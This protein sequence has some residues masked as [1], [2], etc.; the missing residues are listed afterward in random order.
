MTSIRTIVV[1]TD[2]SDVTDHVLGQ[3]I[4]LC[5][6][7]G[8]SI[9]LVHSVRLPALSGVPAAGFPSGVWEAIHSSA[10]FQMEELQKKVEARGVTVSTEVVDAQDPAHAAAR[11]A[12]EHDADWIVMGTHGHT[13]LAHSLLGSVAE[14]TIRAAQVPVLSVKQG[15]RGIEE[16]PER[17]LMATDFSPHSDRAIEVAGDYASRVGAHVHLLHAFE[18]PGNYVPYTM[19]MAADFGMLIQ[20]RATEALSQA[21]DK[22]RSRGLAVEEHLVRG[23]PSKVVLEEAE[24]LQVPLVAMGTRGAGGLSH[25]LLGSVAERTLRMAPCAVL[26][27]RAE[28]HEAA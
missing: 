5:A 22:L 19:P 7:D 16:R 20:T 17:I 26:T 4:A 18:I 23:R 9:H 25:L 6:L 10:R 1:P 21:A 24:R 3:A 12:E 15:S 11:S 13:G 2:F 28:E 8:G 27:V 14:R